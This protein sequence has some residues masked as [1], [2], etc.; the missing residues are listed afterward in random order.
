MNA[1]FARCSKWTNSK[2]RFRAGQWPICTALQY[3]AS[4]TQ[5]FIRNSLYG[6]LIDRQTWQN[7]EV[8]QVVF[9]CN[10]LI[11]VIG[12]IKTEYPG[13]SAQRNSSSMCNARISEYCFPV[14]FFGVM[15]EM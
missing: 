1:E 14:K 15:Y 8:R 12:G 4:L 6:I 7:A 9:P 2:R 11:P 10:V 3:R 13:R 5:M